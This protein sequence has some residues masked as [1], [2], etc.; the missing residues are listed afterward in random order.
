MS[1]L[2]DIGVIGLAVMG[3]NLV[4]NFADHGYRVAVHNRTVA[5]IDEFLGGE[6]AGSDVV[7][8][9][10]IEE[11]VSVLRP[12]RKI[13]LM[14]KAGPPVDAQ[15]ASLLP[16]LEPGDMVIDGGNSLYSD[17]ERRAAMMEA[18][19]MRYLG[20]G[21]S[22]GEDGA[23]HGPSL[24]PGGTRE[25]WDHVAPMLQD[26]AAKADGEPCAQYLGSGGSGHYV[27]MVHNGIEYGDMQVIAEA[28]D[29]MRRGLG[30]TPADI[31]PVFREWNEGRLDSFLI[32]ITAQIMDVVDDDGTPLVDRVL[33]AAAQ[34]GTGMWTVGAS[35]EQAAPATLVAEAVYAR[36]VSAAVT[37]RSLAAA[38]F[39]MEVQQIADDRDDVLADL[40]DALYA[41]KIVS[42]AQGFMLLAA[43]DAAFG[44]GL[45]PGTIASLWRNGAIIRSRFLNDITGAFRRQ[46][47][48]PNLILAPFFAGELQRAEPG[49]RRT[50]TRATAA[51]IPIPAYASALAFFDGYRSTRLPANLTQAQ[52]DAFGHHTYERVDR[53]RGESFHTDW[54]GSGA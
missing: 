42:Y 25:A 18:A 51:G 49:W 14:I 27:K 6:A 34:K 11:F 48:L 35:V 2:A 17:T 37:E 43:A 33:D 10:T 40:E 4:L 32:E 23:R 28:Y 45:D 26:I 1:D 16:N 24:M 46:P 7:G 29:T 22:G 12:P 50:V 38:A 8:A 19:G 52:R 39:P 15:L 21:I 13:L 9:H 53:P 47:G 36:I 44:W 20:V 31:G 5:K 41:S 54:L 30:M 3:S